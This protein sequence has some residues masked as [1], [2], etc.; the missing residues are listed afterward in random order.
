LNI[1]F[2]ADKQTIIKKRKGKV[3]VHTNEFRIDKNSIITLF[4]PV[5]GQH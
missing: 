1:F 3:T 4:L 5:F 2:L